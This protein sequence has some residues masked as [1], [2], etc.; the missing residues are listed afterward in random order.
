MGFVFAVKSR[1]AQELCEMGLHP[2]RLGLGLAY[3]LQSEHSTQA[4]EFH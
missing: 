2:G 3:G 1:G 4:E